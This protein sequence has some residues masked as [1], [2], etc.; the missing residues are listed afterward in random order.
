[1]NFLAHNIRDNF[2]DLSTFALQSPNVPRPLSVNHSSPMNWSS[3]SQVIIQGITTTQTIEYVLQMKTYGTQ[4]VAAINPGRGGDKIED[5]PIFDLV[6]EAIAEF[7][8][9]DTSLIFVSPYEVLDAGREAIAAGIKRIIIFTTEV[10]PLDIISL[11]QY[12][13]AH[14]TL[15][16]GPGSEGIVIPEQICLGK[17]QPEFYQPGT[18]GLISSS[19]HLSY[20]VAWELNQAGIGQSIAVSLGNEPILGSSLATWLSILNGDPQTK[21]IVAIGNNTNDLEEIIASQEQEKYDKPIV[22]YIV[23]LNTPQ[24]KVFQDATTIITNHLSFSIPVVNRDR[25]NITELSKMGIKVAKRLDLIPDLLQ[26]AMSDSKIK[27][28]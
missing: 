13:A 25:E 18:V 20:E 7:D 17:L 4:V 12:A 26:K 16:L 21:A 3:Q 5:I 1:M 28:T 10:P 11:L 27:S 15:V 2:F 22:V 9:I 23:G 19:K 8:Q 24:E 14:Q 6:E